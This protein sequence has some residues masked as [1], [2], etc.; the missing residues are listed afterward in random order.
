MSAVLA[1]APQIS[2]SVADDE[3]MIVPFISTWLPCMDPSEI[4]WKYA[5]CRCI[6]LVRFRFILSLHFSF[7]FKS[8]ISLKASE[9]HKG[10]PME[11]KLLLILLLLTVSFVSVASH[12]VPALFTFGD[13]IFDAGNNHFNRNC[14]VQADFPPYGRSFFH[15]PSGRFTDGRIV[16]DFICKMIVFS[17]FS[18][19]FYL[20][21]SLNLL[22]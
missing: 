2:C 12:N 13:S 14:S 9:T 16:V 19:K 17:N 5:N 8:V 3:I 1:I 10:A 7:Q 18:L 4:F 15:H 20:Y 21:T 6:V 22:D 11:I